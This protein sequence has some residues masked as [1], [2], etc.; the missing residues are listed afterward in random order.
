M[1]LIFT[2]LLIRILN[3]ASERLVLLVDQ[4]NTISEWTKA[5]INDKSKYIN[6]ARRII[7]DLLKNRDYVHS[8]LE[9][10]EE[11]RPKTLTGEQETM[12]SVIRKMFRWSLSEYKSIIEYAKEVAFDQGILEELQK[13]TGETAN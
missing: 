11:S 8:V 9:A 10:L 5:N 3:L 2:H 13:D 12:V 7:D 6:D 1:K 4:H